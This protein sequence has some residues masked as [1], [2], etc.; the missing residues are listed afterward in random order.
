M[1]GKVT[2]MSKIKQLIQLHDRG[3][4]N[5]KIA[6]TLGLNKGTVNEYV[7]KLPS[8]GMSTAELL[9]IDDPVLEGKFCAGTAAFTD[10]RFGEFKELLPYFERELGRKHVTRYLLWREYL[11]KHPS[12]YRYTQFC[13]HLNQQLVVRKATAIL[14][15]SAGERMFVDFA[16]ERLEYVDSA[17]GEIIKCQVFVACLP[18]S[19]YSFCMAV[20]SQ[21]TDDFL[22]AISC[23]LKA[24][25]GVAQILV[26]DNLKAAVIKS[27]RYEPKLNQVLEDFANHYGF[28]VCPTRVRHPKDK[29]KVESQV[30]I[31]YSRVYAKLR[32]QTFYSI[33][34][35]NKALSEKTLEHNQTRMQRCDYS[36]QERFIA[37][38]KDKL[39]PL[40]LTDFEK[41]YY[42]EL[43]VESNCCIYLARDKH[44]Y[45]VPYQHIGEKVQVIYTRTLVKIYYRSKLVATHQRTVGHGYTTVKEHLCSTHRFYRE[46]SAEFYINEAG[47]KSDTFKALIVN[48]FNKRNYPPELSYKT[49]D[50]LLS[51]SRKTNPVYFEEACQTAIEVEKFSYCF[52]RDLIQTRYKSSEREK[53][54]PLPKITEVRGKHYYK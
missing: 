1:S 12:G 10:S 14:D 18:Y 9:H 44:Y 22:Y 33:E 47:K 7:N 30:R 51:L 15:H 25:G 40:P 2:T 54:K 45:S 48:I 39:R 29:A 24:F 21:S 49:C 37:S 41:K 50:G 36:R 11:E 35:L 52:V 6:A 42:A 32:N 23:A 16:G 4:S 46:R 28:V 8:I 3:V 31:I 38:E 26:P 19:D 5:R 53:Y 13:H 17:T 34:E 43:K 27:D 20:P